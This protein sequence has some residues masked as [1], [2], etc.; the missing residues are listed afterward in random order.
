MSSIVW[1]ERLTRWLPVVGHG[2]SSR[3]AWAL[4]FLLLAQLL[5]PQTAM[6]QGGPYTVYVPLVVTTPV[7]EPNAEEAAVA[8]LFAHDPG[9]TRT[10]ITCSPVLA[11]VARARAEDMARRHYF[12]HT[13]PDG[14][15]P[16]YLAT[17]AG[18]RLPSYYSRESDGNNIESIAAG[19]AS[20][21]DVWSVWMA[22]D[23]HRSHLLADNGFY[24]EQTE[25][26]VGYFNDP[27]SEYGHYWVILTAKA[28]D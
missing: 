17:Q 24:R 28:G 21:A 14:F 11:E 8:D 22:S 23:A 12:N 5:I 6:A 10:G 9:Q 16:N 2:P 18:F 20:P 26:G 25:I 1:A 7:C 15:G 19:V 3:V 13:N 27:T 4:G